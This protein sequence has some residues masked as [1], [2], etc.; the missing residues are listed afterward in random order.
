LLPT[1]HLPTRDLAKVL[2]ICEDRFNV[3]EHAVWFRHERR[4]RL[5]TQ[6]SVCTEIHGLQR[7]LLV[8]NFIRLILELAHK[9]HPPVWMEDARRAANGNFVPVKENWPDCYSES[10]SEGDEEDDSKNMPKDS[11]WRHQMYQEQVRAW[12]AS[13]DGGP[14]L[15]SDTQVGPKSAAADSRASGFE[16]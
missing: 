5:A 1:D 6:V 11:E 7:F 4:E 15:H 13:H 3:G 12:H 10:D 16:W 8:R 14:Q 9:E 2:L